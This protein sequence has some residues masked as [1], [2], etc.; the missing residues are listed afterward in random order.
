[1]PPYYAVSFTFPLWFTSTLLTHLR[2]LKIL[3]LSSPLRGCPTKSFLIGCLNCGYGRFYSYKVIGLMLVSCSGSTILFSF[4]LPL[5]SSGSLIFLGH[6]VF[7]FS[8]YISLRLAGSCTSF[9][10]FLPVN[11]PLSDPGSNLAS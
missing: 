7:F 2:F 8:F 11:I 9:I 6:G 4:I 10:L 5:L 3:C 1:M